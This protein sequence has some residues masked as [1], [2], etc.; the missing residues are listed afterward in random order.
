ME[1]VRRRT[2]EIT[3]DTTLS[4]GTHD[5]AILVCSQPVT[6][7]PAFVDMGSSFACTIVNLSCGR[8]TFAPG[9]TTSNGFRTLPYGSELADLHAFTYSGGNVVLV[10]ME[11]G[12]TTLGPP[13]QVTRVTA[14]VS[15]V[16]QRRIVMAST[17]LRRYD[18]QLCSQLPPDERRRCLDFSE[19]DR[20]EPHDQQSGSGYNV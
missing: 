11:G 9:I 6:L 8:V 1:P 3:M 17:N 20:A 13:G 19:R 18:E 4:G 7:T 16:E 5:G 2:L 14:A 15:C 12:V 10:E